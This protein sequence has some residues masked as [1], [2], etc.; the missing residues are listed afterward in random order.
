VND[1]ASIESH[2][3]AAAGRRARSLS[4]RWPPAP[5]TVGPT[6]PSTGSA[7][8]VPPNAQVVSFDVVEEATTPVSGIRDA[9]RLV[10]T[11]R[12]T[13]Q[14][15]WDDFHSTV[16]PKPE[17]PAIDFDARM[18]IAATLGE[19]TSG[20]YA[21]SVPEV[22]REGD[23]L[24][25]V[26]EEAAPGTDCVTATVMTTPAVAVSVP[27]PGARSCSWSAR[28]RI[29]AGPAPESSAPAAGRPAE[30]TGPPPAADGGGRTPQ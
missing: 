30:T 14:A 16:V 9:R 11:D 29:P 13:W 27:A 15:F 18:V 19:R 26:I 10:I 21:I 23:A 3:P 17:P 20:G 12:A 22:A 7:E 2:L 6:G 4:G 1:D 24:Y 8:D 25:V 28:S 5:T